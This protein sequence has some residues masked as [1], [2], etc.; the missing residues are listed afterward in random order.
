MWAIG[1]EVQ[2][3]VSVDEHQ[4]DGEAIYLGAVVRSL[5]HNGAV[6]ELLDKTILALDSFCEVS[7]CTVQGGVRHSLA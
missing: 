6:S 3:L 4:C 1:G 7:R 2:L 5:Q